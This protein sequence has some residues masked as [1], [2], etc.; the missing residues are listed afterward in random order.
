MEGEE[1][2]RQVRV[3]KKVCPMQLSR[4][5][6]IVT[7]KSDIDFD[8]YG[9]MEIAEIIRTSSSSTLLRQSANHLKMIQY[10]PVLFWYLKIKVVL[11]RV[12]A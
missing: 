6:S 7:E 4:Q 3:Y 5:I 11:S 9:K 8:K 10:L 12:I 2:Q 1:E